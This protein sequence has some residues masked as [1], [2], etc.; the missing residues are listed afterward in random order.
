M[1]TRFYL[2]ALGAPSS[3][4]TRI[5]GEICGAGYRVVAGRLDGRVNHGATV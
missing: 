3:P 4:G 2:I 1:T 5:Y